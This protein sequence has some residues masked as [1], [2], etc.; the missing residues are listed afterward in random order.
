[1]SN[2][3][4]LFTIRRL[5][6]QDQREWLRMRLALWP[7]ST[8]EELAPDIQDYLPGSTR[9]AAF[10]S[11]RP[12]GGLG[13]FIEVSQRSYADGCDTRPVG[14]IEGWYVDPDLRRQGVGKALVEAAEGWAASLGCSEMASDA[15][16][17]N[18]VSLLAHQALG[19][20]ITERL[21]H[22]CKKLPAG[23]VQ[24][25]PALPAFIYLIR[26]ARAG[27]F[28][29]PTPAEE[30]VLDRHYEHLRQQTEAGV[31][32]L[33]GPCLDETFGIVVFRA[34][35]LQAAEA[36]MKSDPGVQGG[37]MEAELHPFHVSL[38]RRIHEKA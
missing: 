3:I 6:S 12:E 29:G 18:E 24:P 11:A 17:D 7:D 28:D 20:T 26:P 38:V 37:V 22:F 15:E 21:V 8:A 14:Y 19:Y 34:E 27:F 9:D 31:V 25:P 36:F 32:L 35:S 5:T 2:N 30:A 13:G 23:L 16:E 10:V 33:A 4:K 1:M